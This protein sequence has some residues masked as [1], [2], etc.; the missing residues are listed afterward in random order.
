MIALSIPGSGDLKLKYI[1]LD[2]NG[3]LAQDG[4]LIA[5]V[6][7]RL[8]VL[9]ARIEIHVLT[10]D[11]YGTAQKALKGCPCNVSI[12]HPHRQDLAKARYVK[13]L[14]TKQTAAIGNGLNDSRMLKEAALGIAV[15]QGEGA[16]LR[17]LLEADIVSTDIRMALG[18]LLNPLRLTATLRK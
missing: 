17:T 11:T 12:I 6:R 1:V 5:G 16:A 4:I 15:I 9:A 8:K 14:G 2:F 3:T 7:K 18:L 13:R 10:A